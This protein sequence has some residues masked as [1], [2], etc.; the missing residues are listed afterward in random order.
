MAN[1]RL[2]VVNAIGPRSGRANSRSRLLQVSGVA[3]EEDAR[4]VH[5]HKRFG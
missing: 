4:I 5:H 2:A 1:D 3:S